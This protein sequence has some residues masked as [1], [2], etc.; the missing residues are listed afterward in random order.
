[1][2]AA[3]WVGWEGVKEK[4]PLRGGDGGPR[5]LELGVASGSRCARLCEL[6]AG[7]VWNGAVRLAELIDSGCLHGRLTGKAVLELGAGAALPSLVLLSQS[8]TKCS[9]SAVVISDYDDPAIIEAIRDNVE[10]NAALLHTELCRVVGHTWGTDASPL[11][12][13]RAS[14]L[15]SCHAGPRVE[16]HGRFD[17]VLLAEIMW[18]TELHAALIES[19]C[20][21]LAPNGEILMCHC[22]HWEGH[23]K[24]DQHFFKLAADRGVVVEPCE[25]MNRDMPCLFSGET[26]TAHVFRLR[27]AAAVAAERLVATASLPNED[28]HSETDTNQLATELLT[29]AEA[30]ADVAPITSPS[31]EPSS[32]DALASLETLPDDLLEHVCEALL[33][34]EGRHAPRALAALQRCCHRLVTSTSAVGFLNR[35]G[36]CVGAPSGAIRSLEQ[37][38]VYSAVQA[39]VERGGALVGFEFAG[40]ALDD[41]AGTDS[42]LPGTRAILGAWANFLRRHPSVVVRIDAHCGVTAPCALAPS[43]SRRRGLSVAMELASC[44]IS[45]QRVHIC[46]WGKQLARRAARSSHANGAPARMGCGWAELFAQWPGD[47]SRDAEGLVELPLRPDYY[48]SLRRS[49]RTPRLQCADDVSDGSDGGPSDL[50]PRDAA[51][52]SGEEGYSTDGGPEA[53]D[54]WSSGSDAGGD[55]RLRRG[56]GG[57]PDPHGVSSDEEELLL[58]RGLLDE[59]DDDDDDDDEVELRR[60]DEA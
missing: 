5:H 18:N 27:W 23:E 32:P 41:E 43:Y 22:R 52:Q 3:G 13:A 11:L 29:S 56:E 20:K 17:V 16:P 2:Q 8:T 55:G 57:D 50:D 39:L 21:L 19:L 53:A 26:Q 37:L 4:Y 9:P 59:Q 48:P 36:A 47:D 33:R 45:L 44:G 12:A 6:H 54:G 58:R 28:R 46:G 1:M 49:G 38:A 30:L 25:A 34:S 10:S 60:G 15:G 42:A 31:G 14:I 40:T 7:S 51:A 24:A 35:L